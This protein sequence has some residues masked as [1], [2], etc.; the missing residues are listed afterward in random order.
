ME[1]RTP[2]HTTNLKQKKVNQLKKEPNGQ[3]QLRHL[4]MN[5]SKT[6]NDWADQL[7]IPKD[8]IYCENFLRNDRMRCVFKFL[9]KSIDI[10][11]SLTSSLPSF[12]KTV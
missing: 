4:P 12:Q 3:Y 1:K 11:K 7:L 9:L 10:L 8:R 5:Y 6:C 2:S